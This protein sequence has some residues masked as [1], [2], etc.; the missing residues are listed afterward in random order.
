[1]SCEFLYYRTCFNESRTL[2]IRFPDYFQVGLEPHGNH[3]IV[4]YQHTDVVNVELQ[5]VAVYPGY[6]D[7]HYRHT[8]SHQRVRHIGYHMSCH[9]IQTLMKRV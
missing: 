8:R 4:C 9:F 2:I 1:M 7:Q 5:D 6:H 3:S